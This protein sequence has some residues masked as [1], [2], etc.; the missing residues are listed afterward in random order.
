MSVFEHWPNRITA[1][2]FVGALA[3]FSI[4]AVYGAKPAET[5][6]L[7]LHIAFWL[8]IVVAS[9]DALDGYLARRDNQVSAFGRI[10]DPFVDKVLIVG[11]MVYLATMPWSRGFMPATVVVLTLAREFLV[12]AIRGYVE[13]VG[14]EFPADG[15]GKF[16]MIMQCVTIGAVLC[17]QIVAWPPAF[18]AFLAFFAHAMVW[19]TLVA[20]VGSGITYS[21][22]TRGV[23]LGEQ[24]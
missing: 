15:F 2:R 8:F 19:T 3:L 13:S 7:E 12:T 23:L 11:A 21:L 4:F 6:R 20:T 24:A 16:K 17:T 9:T 18:Y 1:S 14:R 22:R 10:A 5:I